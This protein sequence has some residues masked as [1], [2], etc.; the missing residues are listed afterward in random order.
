MKKQIEDLTVTEAT[1]IDR[2]DELISY[3][4]WKRH[5]LLKEK[6][7]N[8]T[9]KEWCKSDL[10]EQGYKMLKQIQVEERNEHYTPF[11]AFEAINEFILL[12]YS[13]FLAPPYHA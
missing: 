8:M 3:G 9:V 10:F 4:T 2:I 11:S 12:I 5:K 13:P 7:F 6:V 1:K